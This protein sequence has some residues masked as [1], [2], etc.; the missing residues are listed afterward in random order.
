M[1]IYRRVKAGDAYMYYV[2]ID[3]KT[4]YRFAVCPNIMKKGEFTTCLLYRDG[5]DLIG[6]LS[7]GNSTAIIFQGTMKECRNNAFNEIDKLE[8][9]RND[10]G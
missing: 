9:E 4:C 3:G 6:G 5:V 1:K 2:F 10:K 8:K 7:L